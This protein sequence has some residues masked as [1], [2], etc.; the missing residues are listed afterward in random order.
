[1]RLQKWHF[2]QSHYTVL[3]K[4][5][6]FCNFVF[7]FYLN[8]LHNSLSNTKLAECKCLLQVFIYIK[9]CIQFSLHLFDNLHNFF[10]A[11]HIAAYYNFAV[12]NKRR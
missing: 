10:N 11:R 4:I 1:M 2:L 12:N 3:C 5:W 7:G 6:Q 9:F 8:V